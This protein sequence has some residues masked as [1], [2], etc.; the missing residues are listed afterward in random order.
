MH[1]STQF[2]HIAQNYSQTVVTK[3][4]ISVEENS[5]SFLISY[6]FHNWCFYY[7]VLCYYSVYYIRILFWARFKC[8][9]SQKHFCR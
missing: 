5:R 7:N 6:S 8:S 4:P 9:V 1:L 3:Q 2:L